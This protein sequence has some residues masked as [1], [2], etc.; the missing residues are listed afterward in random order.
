M[1]HIQGTSGLKAAFLTFKMVR[2]LRTR[3]LRLRKGRR[4]SRKRRGRGSS[5]IASLR[6]QWT[7]Y[8]P[9]R[10]VTCRSKTVGPNGVSIRLLLLTITIPHKSRLEEVIQLV[11]STLQGNLRDTLSQF[12]KT[13]GGQVNPELVL[14][15]KVQ[16]GS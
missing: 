14:E 6:N 1:S 9:Q 8:C 10:I 4:S 7:T 12:L 3:L 13:T 16:G 11:T 5:L 15:I 2:K